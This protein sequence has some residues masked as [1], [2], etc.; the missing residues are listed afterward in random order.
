MRFA[1]CG[2]IHLSHNVNALIYMFSGYKRV[3]HNGNIIND[4]FVCVHGGI[5][6]CIRCVL[7]W[8]IF[9]VDLEGVFRS[10]RRKL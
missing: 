9:K 8:L 2:A 10:N 6:S 4:E 5:N 7:I 1:F 3:V